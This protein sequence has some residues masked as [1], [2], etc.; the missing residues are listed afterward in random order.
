MELPSTLGT[1]LDQILRQRYRL[2]TGFVESVLLA[3]YR[4]PALHLYHRAVVAL[5]SHNV[6]VSGLENLAI[7]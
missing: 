3:V 1:Y 5:D 4:V 6:G 7:M 2:V